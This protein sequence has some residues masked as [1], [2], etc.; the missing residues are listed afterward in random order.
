MSIDLKYEFVIKGLTNALMDSQLCINKTA[1]QELLLKLCEYNNYTN[2]LTK[3]TLTEIQTFIDNNNDI[4]KNDNIKNL[5]LLIANNKFVSD[6]NLELNMLFN[7][8]LKCF[9][10][11]EK[12]ICFNTDNIIEILSKNHPIKISFDKLLCLNKYQLIVKQNTENN[13]FEHKFD[14]ILLPQSNAFDM[15]DIVKDDVNIF[16]TK[17]M[18][19]SVSINNGKVINDVIYV[20]I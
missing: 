12:E 8:V 13:I 9:Y 16:L 14:D 3:D 10:N 17:Q 7:Q 15:F 11:V 20:E 4:Y 18:E 19:F 5:R 6:N 1:C 2:I